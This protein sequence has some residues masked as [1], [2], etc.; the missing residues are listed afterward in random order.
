MHT[1]FKPIFDYHGFTK[2]GILTYSILTCV[3]LP[4]RLVKNNSP[5]V[6]LGGHLSWGWIP[7]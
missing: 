1:R 6:H 3:L 2:T 7:F 4:Y 5:Q